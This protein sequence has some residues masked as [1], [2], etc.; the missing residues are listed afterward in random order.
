VT[1]VRSD[2]W[3][4][5]S[6]TVESFVFPAQSPDAPRSLALT[7]LLTPTLVVPAGY[8]LAVA[9]SVLGERPQPSN[10]DLDR[11]LVR[12]GATVLAVLVAYALPAVISLVIG[13]PVWV[14]GGLGFVGAYLGPAAVV[15]YADEGPRS[16]IRIGALLDVVLTASYL[17]TVIGSVLIG[18]VVL[19]L[20]RWGIAPASRWAAIIAGVWLTGYL[21]LVLS[22]R[23]ASQYE[24]LRDAGKTV[25]HGMVGVPV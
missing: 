2:R 17:R 25:D 13:G 1:G 24:S 3:I 7:C 5:R 18:L 15:S 12:E 4:P 23:Q 16:A 21:G 22:H 8:A 9:R 10:L 20:L 14:S 11:T 6:E 19:G